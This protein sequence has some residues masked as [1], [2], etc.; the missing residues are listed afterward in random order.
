M[1]AFGFVVHSERREAWELGA[2]LS[3]WLRDRGH[4][5]R[6]DPDDARRC[7]L[8]D[9]ACSPDELVVG[10]DLLVGLGGDGTMLG[11]VD[12]AAGDDVPV[13]GVNIGQLGYLTSIEPDG[14][15]V[16]LKRFLSGSFDVEERMR[17]A[18]AIER[19]DGSIEESATALNEALVGGSAL[20]HTIRLDVALDGE[21]FTPYVADAMLVATPTGSTAYA[22]S[23]RGPIV[24]PRHRAQILVPVAPHMLFDRALVLQAST[25]IRLTVRG[26]R[27][28]SLSVDGRPSGA[29]AVGDSVLCRAARTPAR[30]VRIGPP[31]F[32]QVLKA[33]FGLS[34]R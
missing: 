7:G 19:A 3:R 21:M 15:R 18:C 11:A 5:V 30:L 16:A 34:D 33:K 14:A 1:A 24:D 32:H 10:L 22:L 27:A 31:H 23:A 9:L 12:R 20:G 28:A 6:L 4:E 2:E 17:I 8:A 25:E 26:V 13:L 29:L